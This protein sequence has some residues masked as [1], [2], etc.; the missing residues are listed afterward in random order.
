MTEEII[1]ENEILDILTSK[2]YLKKTHVRYINENCEIEKSLEDF[3][4]ENEEWEEIDKLFD[5]ET[6]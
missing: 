5:E 6:K 2:K 1:D 3:K 4:K